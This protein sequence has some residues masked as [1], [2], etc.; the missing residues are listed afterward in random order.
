MVTSEVKVTVGRTWREGR[1]FWWLPVRIRREV[2]VLVLAR[3]EPL[4]HSILDYYVVPRLANIGG[5]F[6]VRA[7]KNVAFLDIHRVQS[8]SVLIATLRCCRIPETP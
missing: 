8:L 4:K 7:A 3:V 2:D 1:T 5:K 6:L